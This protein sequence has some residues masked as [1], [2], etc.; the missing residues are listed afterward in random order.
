MHKYVE[1]GLQYCTLWSSSIRHMKP[2]HVTC[3]QPWQIEF[4]TQCP[5]YCNQG[6]QAP[7]HYHPTLSSFFKG[8]ERQA[9]CEGS[10]RRGQMS[11]EVFLFVC[12]PSSS[13]TLTPISLWKIL[14]RV[15]MHR[16]TRTSYLCSH[17]SFSITFRFIP[18]MIWD[19]MLA[20]RTLS[21]SFPICLFLKLPHLFPCLCI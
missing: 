16:C 1:D 7:H 17:S 2:Q 20:S 15:E 11:K 8:R 13:V 14:S 5:H 4:T 10:D 6:N 19:I 3:K 21:R 9:E 18:V 12:L